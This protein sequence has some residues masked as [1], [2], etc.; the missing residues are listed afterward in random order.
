V[1]LIKDEEQGFSSLHH[2]TDH[3]SNRNDPFEDSGMV[4]VP[5]AE[6]GEFII[7]L[8]FTEHDISFHT[9]PIL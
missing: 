6:K 1:V 9:W 3:P 8:S 5:L 7:F 4:E 2:L